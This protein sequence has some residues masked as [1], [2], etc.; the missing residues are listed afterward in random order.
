MTPRGCDPS[1]A[2]TVAAGQ[3]AGTTRKNAR[4]HAPVIFSK[5]ALALNV[6]IHV[7]MPVADETPV[8]LRL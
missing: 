7:H 3:R 6:N 2:A 5:G 1:D 8:E 4:A